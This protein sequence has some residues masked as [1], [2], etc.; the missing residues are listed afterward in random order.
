MALLDSFASDLTTSLGVKV[1]NLSIAE[2]WKS[3]GP[4]K[5]RG[6][7]ID[8]FFDEVFYSTSTNT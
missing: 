2:L 3:V 1:S 6:Q 7:T 8:E 4:E 5:A